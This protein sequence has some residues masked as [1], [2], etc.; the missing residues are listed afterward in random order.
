MFAYFWRRFWS[1]RIKRVGQVHGRDLIAGD[2]AAAD[3]YRTYLRRKINYA[4]HVV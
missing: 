2:S 1:D 3:R 4:E